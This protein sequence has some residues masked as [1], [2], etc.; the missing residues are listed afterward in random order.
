M[1]AQL[2]GKWG[3]GGGGGGQHENINSNESLETHNTWQQA[4]H[5]NIYSDLIQA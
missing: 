1:L 5:L 4:E 2:S 3:G